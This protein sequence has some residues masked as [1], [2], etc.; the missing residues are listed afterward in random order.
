[1][2]DMQYLNG[3]ALHGLFES[4]Y[5]NLK[6][7]TEAINQLNVFPVPDGDT[8]TNMVRTF[9]DIIIRLSEE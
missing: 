2:I 4:G 3:A 1:M 8:G 5:R 7:N 9:G 6:K